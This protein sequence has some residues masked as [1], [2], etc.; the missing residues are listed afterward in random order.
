MKCME[1]PYQTW[2]LLILGSILLLNKV[3]YPNL[4]RQNSSTW[5]AF[6]IFNKFF[7]AK[8][9]GLKLYCRVSVFGPD[10]LQWI[11]REWVQKLESDEA[12]ACFE[13]EKYTK[14]DDLTSQGERTLRLRIG[15]PNS[16][17]IPRAS[18]LSLGL[19]LL[20]PSPLLWVVSV[21]IYPSFLF[22]LLLHLSVIH[23]HTRVHVQSITLSGALWAVVAPIAL[24]RGHIHINGVKVLTVGI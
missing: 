11:C 22:I 17:R 9:F 15:T 10:L 4:G 1:H 24:S 7:I 21:V 23:A 6:Q 3:F 16:S 19:L 2:P 5:I 18:L 8:N 20:P 13:G 14:S 12:T